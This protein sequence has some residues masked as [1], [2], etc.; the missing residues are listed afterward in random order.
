MPSP[1]S[2]VW[3]FDLFAAPALWVIES[4]KTGTFDGLGTANGNNSLG[5]QWALIMN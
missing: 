3:K 2:D 4:L 5:E 1:I